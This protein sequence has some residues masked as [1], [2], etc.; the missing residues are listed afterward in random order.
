MIGFLKGRAL[1][2]TPETALVDVGGVGYL[3]HIPLSTYYELERRG[4]DAPVELFVHTHAREDALTLFGFLSEQEKTLF[5]R[6]I[7]ISGVGPRLARNILS[8][9]PPEELIATLAAGDVVRLTK[10]PGVGKKTAERLVLELRDRVQDL[11]AELP[12][13]SAAPSVADDLVS[14]LVNLGYRPKQAERA[15]AEARDEAPDAAF[16]ELLRA[17]LRRLARV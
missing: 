8:A 16:H 14:A 3:V 11:A 6:L 1:Q 7:T 4:A 13:P 12:T 5:E 9:A 2:L 17:S 10:T 15:V